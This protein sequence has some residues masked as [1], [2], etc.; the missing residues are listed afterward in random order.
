MTNQGK[1]GKQGKKRNA[2]GR[3]VESAEGPKYSCTAKR[4]MRKK[5]KEAW[6]DITDILVKTAKEGD[7]RAMKWLW[8]ESG[9]GKEMPSKKRGSK[10]GFAQTLIEEI[11]R[12]Q[13][14]QAAA[15]A[16]KAETASETP[17]AGT[18]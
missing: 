13:A 8:E 1:Q 18:T 17:K 9:I 16:G 6:P 4:V 7:F 12:H 14:E 3:F 2:A 5:V 11:K 15:K 10:T